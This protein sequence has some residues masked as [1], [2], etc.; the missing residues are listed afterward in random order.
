MLAG[1]PTHSPIPLLGVEPNTAVV[2]KVN[3]TKELGITV[4]RLDDDID[5][6]R[7]SA[8]ALLSSDIFN[9]KSIFARGSTPD[10]IESFDSYDEIKEMRETEKRLLFKNGLKALNIQLQK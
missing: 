4:E 10:T 8:N 7:L 2:L 5:I 6:G 9:F 1:G 3:R